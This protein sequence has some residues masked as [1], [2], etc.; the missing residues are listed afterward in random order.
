VRLLA[1]AVLFF[2][3]TCTGAEGAGPRLAPTAVSF[4]SPS[5]G[6]VLGARGESRVSLLR[7]TSNGGRTWRSLP[8]PPFSSS[9]FFNVGK[10]GASDLDF[11]DAKNG[12][13]FGPALYE[14]H[15]GGVS[16]TQAALGGVEELA[17]GAGYVF[18]IAPGHPLGGQVTD[19]WRARIRGG[20]WSVVA[21]IAA[22]YGAD[23]SVEG[24]TVV[25]LRRGWVGPGGTVS[26]TDNAIW[27]SRTSGERWGRYSVPCRPEIAGASLVAITRGAPDRWLLDCF[28]GLQ[29]SQEQHTRH[30]LY[31]CTQFGR[32]WRRLATPS[33]SGGPARLAATSRS[34]VLVTQGVRGE[35]HASFDGGRHFAL[36]YPPDGADT[37]WGDLA[38]VDSRTG[39]VVRPTVKGNEVDR[40][41]DAGRHWRRLA[42][43]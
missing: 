7:A 29:S 15:D 37:E 25:F 31:L 13:A 8:A 12:Y 43:G 32:G 10:N 17:T 9:R 19:L 38:F 34:I 28:N 14:T 16:W 1:F 36:V 4:V 11:A 22:P 39:F 23:L 35:F 3:L 26:P 20:Q 24:R 30:V 42:V 33:D 18:A 41:D 21:E 40:T 5:T 27:A 2:A 6:W